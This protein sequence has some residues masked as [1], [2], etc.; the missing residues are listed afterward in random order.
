MEKR[1]KN[2]FISLEHQDK[3]HESRVKNL[4]EQS[5]LV[6]W[7][8][9]LRRLR[10]GVTRGLSQIKQATPPALQ[11]IGIS[12]VRSLFS[13][14]KARLLHF[15]KT[16]EP[17]SIYELAKLTGRDF[18]I[19]RQDLRLLEKFGLIKLAHQKTKHREKLKPLLQ[20]RNLN[21]LIN[22]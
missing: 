12:D 11:P 9:A 22:L 4:L 1:E 6:A 7:V 19:V 13:N 10:S 15:I 17:G 14:E 8:P 3:K 2:I 16:R 18:K 20:T 21:L 5:G